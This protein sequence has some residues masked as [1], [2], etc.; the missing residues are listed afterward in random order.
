MQVDD[1]DKAY[2]RIAKAYM[3]MG[4]TKSMSSNHKQAMKLCD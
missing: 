2:V 1:K 3:N 4:L